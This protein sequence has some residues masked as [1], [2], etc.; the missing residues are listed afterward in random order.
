MN[1]FTEVSREDFYTNEEK[2]YSVFWSITVMGEAVG[3]IS[4]EFRATHLDI[5]WREIIGIR[6]ILVHNY[7]QIDLDIICGVI[8]Y[9]APRWSVV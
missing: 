1:R 7:V 2:Q 5:P 3:K 9:S 4:L 8:T 6:N